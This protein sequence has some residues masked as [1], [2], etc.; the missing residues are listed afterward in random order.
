MSRWQVSSHRK[1]RAVG[2]RHGREEVFTVLQEQ[3]LST[4]AQTLRPGHLGWDE[5]ARNASV[6]EIVGVPPRWQDASYRQYARSARKLAEQL[7]AVPS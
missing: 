3:G 7:A 1:A 6:A 5:G 2:S 4:V